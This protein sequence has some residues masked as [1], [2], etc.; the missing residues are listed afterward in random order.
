LIPLSSRLRLIA[1]VGTLAAILLTGVVAHDA[2]ASADAQDAKQAKAEVLEVCRA[3]VGMDDDIGG[4]R[5]ASFFN[6]IAELLEPGRVALVD[7]A[8]SGAPEAECALDYL[9]ELGD[10]RAVP[11]AR[12]ILNRRRVAPGLKVSAIV[13]VGEFKDVASVDQIIEAFKRHEAWKTDDD[14]QIFKAAARALARLPDA[15]GRSV[16]NAALADTR[17]PKFQHHTLIEA[18]GELGN[19]EAIPVLQKL[20]ADAASAGDVGL[21]GFVAV[22]LAGIGPRGRELAIRDLEG[23][24]NYTVRRS[25]ARSM[26]DKW[27]RQYQQMTDAAE[28]AEIERSIRAVEPF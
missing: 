18:A 2:G 25:T 24:T 7:V 23:I 22:S 3:R 5:G 6:R 14:E 10:D 1:C 17:Y 20:L 19:D 13:A 8:G 15:R 28:R 11:P 16:L 21:R 9:L 27:H 4:V 12:K 26:V